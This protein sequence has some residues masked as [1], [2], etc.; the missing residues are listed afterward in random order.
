MFPSTG[1]PGPELLT[2]VSQRCT[3][4]QEAHE[5]CPSAARAPS[6]ANSAMPGLAGRDRARV[7]VKR[8]FTSPRP[9]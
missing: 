3:S 1:T 8:R 5:R 2:S 6:S 4:W 9:G 7:S